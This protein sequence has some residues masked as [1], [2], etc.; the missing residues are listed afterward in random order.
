MGMAAGAK[1]FRSEINITPLVDVVLVLL[2]IF[3]VLTPLLEKEMLVRVPEQEKVE[4][5]TEVPPD[6][7]VLQ[8]REGGRIFVNTEEV[9][10]ASLVE[11]LTSAF[12][13]KAEAQRV[14]FFDAEDHAPYR[15][16]VRALD[17]A[18][19]AKIFTIG[20]MT[21]KASAAPVAAVAQ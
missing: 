8:V 20:M 14:L 4:V 5:V 13:G 16:A 1:G 15:A 21:E 18:R 3:M 9:P 2:I 7:I 12:R 17:L 10:E 11:R 6:Q 19:E